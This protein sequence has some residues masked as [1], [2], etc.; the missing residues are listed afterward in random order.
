[1][2]KALL[3]ICLIMLAVTGRAKGFKTKVQQA[4]YVEKHTAITLKKL[5][6]QVQNN[7]AE[8]KRLKKELI[9]RTPILETITIDTDTQT[10]VT[11]E[12]K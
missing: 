11:T 2:K 9:S 12:A 3:I 7:T 8:I 1:M 5:Q 10:N 4:E 6:K